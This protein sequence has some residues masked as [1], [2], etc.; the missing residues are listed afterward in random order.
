MSLRKTKRISKKD[1]SKKTKKDKKR[2]KQKASAKQSSSHRDFHSDSED[3]DDYQKRR[4]KYSKKR[5][6]YEQVKTR[7]LLLKDLPA[8]INESILSQFFQS[9]SSNLQVEAPEK[10]SVISSF[11]KAFVTFPDV[12][13]LSLLLEV[14]VTRN[15]HPDSRSWKTSVSKES[16]IETA[17]KRMPGSTEATARSLGTAGDAGTTTLLFE[18]SASSARSAEAKMRWPTRFFNPS[19]LSFRLTQKRL[20]GQLHSCVQWRRF[21][22]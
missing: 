9:L 19:R 17:S 7:V 8:K 6:K 14:K 3:S 13:S 4:Q 22:A 16:I 18:R 5:R 2:K 10:I 12:E 15:T 11:K 1:S 21:D 20:G